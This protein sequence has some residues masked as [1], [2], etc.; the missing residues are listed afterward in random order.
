MIVS[1][2]IPKNKADKMSD[3]LINTEIFGAISEI[4]TRKSS[5][6]ELRAVCRKQTLGLEELEKINSVVCLFGE[7]TLKHMTIIPGAYS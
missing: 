3:L 2:L 7:Q 5:L 6:S 4:P 1:V